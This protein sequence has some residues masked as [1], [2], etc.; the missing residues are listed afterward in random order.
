MSPVILPVNTSRFSLLSRLAVLCGGLP[1]RFS[2]HSALIPAAL[3][4]LP[5]FAISF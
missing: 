2:P 3:I 5:H 4:T 1:H